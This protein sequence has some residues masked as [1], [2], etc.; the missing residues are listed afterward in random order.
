MLPLSLPYRIL[1]SA[2]PLPGSDSGSG[3][4][5]VWRVLHPDSSLGASDDPAELARRRP[6]PTADFNIRENG[7]T[8]NS[9]YC[10]WRWPKDQQ[11]RLLREAARRAKNG[12]SSD[13][14][15]RF[16]VPP[17]A[18]DRYGKR[19]DYIFVGTGRAVGGDRDSAGG[20]WVVKTAR[21]GMIEP[22]PT[23]GVSLS[24]HF[25]VEATLVW[26][27]AA[28]ATP[29]K[30]EVGN[31][32][33]AAYP[34]ATAVVPASSRP[35]TATAAATAS[36]PRRDSA[37]AVQDGT[38]LQSPTASSFQGSAKGGSR[39]ETPGLHGAPPIPPL[40]LPS[41]DAADPDQTA[42]LAA[43][44]YD[45]LLVLISAELTRCSSQTRFR[46]AHFFVSL[47]IAIGCLVAI[48]FVAPRAAYGAF[49]LILFSTL[50]LAAGTVD[51][52]LA[53]LFFNGSERAALSEFEWE[54]RNAKAAAVGGGIVGNR[55][56]DDMS[57]H[58]VW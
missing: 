24:D 48:W 9:V 46:A 10:T 19:L 12:G 29:E 26:R 21:V 39:P 20:D 5:D 7:A 36:R 25:S 35:Q 53:L 27:P 23:L 3:M 56:E 37:A 52:L 13:E 32:D 57:N 18:I 15:D 40:I 2:H 51:G 42:G 41:A 47:F 14:K 31:G 49:V 55:H 58:K 1:M 16:K 28:V 38:Y 11:R 45:E 30:T 34:S 44:T 8:S 22:H 17:D 50:G 6:I 43:S 4:R 54:V 33:A